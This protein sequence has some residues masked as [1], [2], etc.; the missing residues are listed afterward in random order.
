MNL[1]CA[2]PSV[3]VWHKKLP[4]LHSTLLHCTAL[5]CCVPWFAVIGQALDAVS[6]SRPKTR[7]QALH[8]DVIYV[9]CEC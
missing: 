1:F 7:E 5:L 9:I 2:S 4:A 6:I 3:M 8:P